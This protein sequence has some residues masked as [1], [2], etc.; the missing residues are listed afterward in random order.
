MKISKSYQ[1]D[2]M[3][4]ISQFNSGLSIPVTRSHPI[5]AQANVSILDDLKTAGI[6]DIGIIIGDFG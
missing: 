6:T 3:N 1:L 5:L 2:A 4:G